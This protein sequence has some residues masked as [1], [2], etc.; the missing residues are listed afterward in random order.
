M[1]L[2]DSPIIP[3]V[4]ALG[5]DAAQAIYSN[6]DKDYSQQG[7]APMIGLSSTAD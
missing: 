1:V 3:T 6:R 2:V 4:A 7:W 5:P